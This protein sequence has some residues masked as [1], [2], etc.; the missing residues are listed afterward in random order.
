M[1]RHRSRAQRDPH[2]PP[3]STR[4]WPLLSSS[5]FPPAVLGRAGGPGALQGCSFFPCKRLSVRPQCP[6]LCQL[7]RV[8]LVPN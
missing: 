3:P 5:G 8:G 7:P 2:T 4:L 1:K 6:G